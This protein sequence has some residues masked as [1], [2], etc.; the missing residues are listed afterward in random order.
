M[1]TIYGRGS[2]EVQ[3][4]NGRSFEIN[5]NRM[6]GYNI[7][8]RIVRLIHFLLTVYLINYEFLWRIAVTNALLDWTA[9]ELCHWSFNNQA[10]CVSSVSSGR[11]DAIRSCSIGDWLV[12]IR[13]NRWPIWSL[14][15]LDRWAGI[16]TYPKGSCFGLDLIVDEVKI[17][18]LTVVPSSGETDALF[19]WKR[20]LSWRLQA[21]IGPPM[22]RLLCTKSSTIYAQHAA[23]G[24]ESNVQWF[25]M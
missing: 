5:W 3:I 12:Y 9:D 15:S 19:G 8:K 1:A 20:K 10:N 25:R 21:K 6:A 13:R 23:V 2:E 24:S 11:I 4:P 16:A 7:A 18:S 22:D 14:L 17:S